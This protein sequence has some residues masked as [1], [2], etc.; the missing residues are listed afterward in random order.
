MQ[1]KY[2]V[3]NALATKWS[4]WVGEYID[5]W[6]VLFQH[7]PLLSCPPSRSVA[8]IRFLQLAGPISII[9]F[10]F[11]VLY[12]TFKDYGIASGSM[13]KARRFFL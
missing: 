8:Y 12:H 5:K 11:C 10:M 7:F 13:N 9:S 2:F 1:Q 6:S 3:K 4:A